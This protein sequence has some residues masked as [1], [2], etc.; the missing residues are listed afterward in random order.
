MM[1]CTLGTFTQ[2]AS[3]EQEAI[4]SQN[5][6]YAQVQRDCDEPSNGRL[7]DDVDIDDTPVSSVDYAADDV[8]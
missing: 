3:N 1:Q 6:P 5:I 7:A 8:D 4:D 2:V